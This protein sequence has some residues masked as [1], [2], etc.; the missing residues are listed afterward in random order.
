MAL[1]IRFG[2][3]EIIELLVEKGAKLDM[4]FAAATGDLSRVKWFVN[5]DGSLA[6][7]AGGINRSF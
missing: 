4:R 7:G 6:S 3:T 2:Q 1:A 5:A